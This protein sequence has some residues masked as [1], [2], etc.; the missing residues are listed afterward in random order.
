M[1]R[2]LQSGSQADVDI[3]V[4]G[5]VGRQS[6]PLHPMALASGKKS[7]RSPVGCETG[8]LL[9]NAPGNTDLEERG[10]SGSEGQRP[11]GKP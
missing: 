7:A 9:L 8:V 5:R 6:H 10:V 1:T 4:E 3:V 11:I 2:Y